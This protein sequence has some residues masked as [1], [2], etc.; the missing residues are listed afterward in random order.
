[1]GRLRQF[2]ERFDEAVAERG[3]RSADVEHSFNDLGVE[4]NFGPVTPPY[5][6]PAVEIQPVPAETP[7]EK[8]K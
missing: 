4:S 1:M 8:E 6:I 7:E 2:I 5:G 3:G